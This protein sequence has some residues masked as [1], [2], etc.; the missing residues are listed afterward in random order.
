M[1]VRTV[2]IVSL[3]CAKN[4]V[5][6][7]QMA[8][9]LILAGYEI[10]PEADGADAVVVNTC[11]FIDAAKREAIDAILEAGELKK[12]GRLRKIIVAGC[13]AERYCDEIARDLPEV[14]AIVGVGAFG[15][16]VAAVEAAVSGSPLVL[17]APPEAADD[18]APRIQTTPRAWAYLKIADGCDNR[19]AFCV[20]PQIRGRY[21][22]RKP[23]RVIAEARHLTENGARE[24]ILI[25]QDT[26]RYGSDLKSGANLAS[27]LRELAEIDGLR[28][29][30][31]HYMYPDAVSDE[32][33]A[34]FAEGG[35]LLPYFDIP[36]QHIN[37]AIL[38]SMRRRGTAEDIRTLFAKIRARVP[39]AVIRTSLIAG[40]PGEGEAEFDEICAFLRESGIE[41]AGVFAF[42]PEEGSEAYGMPRPD[43]ET[44]AR[45]AELLSD[46]AAENAL[47]YAGSRA[48]SLTE[49]LIEEKTD[50]GYLAR[51]FAESPDVD[52]YITVVAKDGALC[53]GEFRTVTIT[54]ARDGVPVAFLK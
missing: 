7:E 12:A 11:G 52:G 41:R 34:L 39:G 4:L 46:V 43:D 13:L 33:L 3:G 51:S 15:E 45:R 2:A 42:S 29:I 38:K 37:G 1:R 53:T 23:E 5:N 21:R 31:V 35:K 27:L 8:A 20:I 48:G 28:W 17:T 24:L 30:R 36:V 10:V 19:C 47:K 18:D 54:E 14:D 22:S 6:S 40:L 44:A 25:A 9:K 16:I 32:L 50:G 26:T 49:V